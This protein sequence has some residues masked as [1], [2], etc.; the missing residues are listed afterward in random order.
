MNI[1]SPATKPITQALSLCAA[2]FAASLA[3]P[4]AGAVDITG[5]VKVNGN[6]MPGVLIGIYDCSNGAFIGATYSGATDSSSG[7]PVNYAISAPMDSVRLELYYHPTPDQVPLADQCRD[8]VLCGQIVPVDGKATVNVD[9]TCDFSEPDPGCVRSPGYWKN[10]PADWPVE[11]IVIGGRKLTKLQA[12][13]LMRLPERGD[14]ARNVFRHLIAA[15]LNVL[16]GA[17][18]RCVA[19]AIEAADAWLARF[20]SGVRASSAPWKRITRVIAHLEAYN[21]GELCAPSC[22]D[23]DGDDK[24]SDSGRD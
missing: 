11:E 8:F 13:L 1:C 7:A 20:P 10:H 4:E 24:R 16:A 9:M 23:D 12:I 6:E 2:L 3:T 19:E 22:D 21:D 17:D 15:K 14:K 18:D 5:L